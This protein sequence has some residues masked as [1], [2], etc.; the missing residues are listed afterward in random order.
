MLPKQH[1]SYCRNLL[2]Y[3]L[4]NFHGACLGT[5]AAGDALGSRIAFLHDHNLHGAGFHTLAALDAQLLIDHVHTGLGILRDGTGF[6]DLGALAALD[7]D[8]GLCFAILAFHDLNA[9]EGHIIGLIE[10][11]GASLHTLQT[12]HALFGFLN[13]ELLHRVDSP[14]I[15]L[16]YPHH[17]TGCFRK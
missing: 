4:Q 6:T 10:C 5:D 7:A 1:L 14:F 13:S 9:A 11:F 17:Y 3:D 2:F 12:G 15:F 16:I 8:I